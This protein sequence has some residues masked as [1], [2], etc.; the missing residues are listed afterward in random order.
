[1][2]SYYS[3]DAAGRLLLIRDMDQHIVKKYDYKYKATGYTFMNDEE[4]AS[5]TRNNCASGYVGSTV[6][7]SV[8]SGTYGSNVSKA[9]ADQQALNDVSANGQNYANT[10]G[11][12]TLPQESITVTNSTTHQITLVMVNT[13]TAQTLTSVVNPGTNNMNLGSM[14]LGTYNVTFT[15]ASPT[16]VYPIIYTINTST[17]TYYGAVSFGNYALNAPAVITFIPGCNGTSCT[18]DANTCIN[19]TCETGVK[20]YTSSVFQGHGT[21]LCTYHYTWSTGLTS[22][23]YTETHSGSCPITLD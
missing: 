5:Y 18:G 10:L 2:T 21:W 17:Q 22:P 6:V 4:H 20:T 23:D 7:Y 14:P 19:N 15:P 1:L 13:V 8:P 9:Q 11:T 12:C 16:I 3:Y